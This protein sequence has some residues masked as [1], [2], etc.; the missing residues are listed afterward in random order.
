[1]YF[2]H[3]G[4]NKKLYLTLKNDNNGIINLTGKT[5]LFTLKDN[6]VTVLQ[7]TPTII[8]ATSGVILVELS[9]SDT[10]TLTHLTFVFE[11]SV[12]G[13]LVETDTLNLYK[14][15]GAMMNNYLSSG[16]T[17]SRPN[18]PTSLYIGFAYFDTTINRVIQWNGTSWI[19]TSGVNESDIT[20]LD[21]R[22]TTNEDNILVNSIDISSLDSR[23]GINESSI[24]SLDGRLDTAE[25]NISTNTGDISALDDRV[26]VIEDDLDNVISQ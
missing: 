4:E 10:S 19:D 6:G 25:S 13:N 16:T 22:V 7:N 17:A 21:S 18:L 14:F 2:M 11:V 26:V 1:M 9:S 20:A 23:V 3:K 15:E 12:N 8:S 5:I 24:I